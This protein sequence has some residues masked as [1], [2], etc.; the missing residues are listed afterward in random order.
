MVAHPEFPAELI[1]A[2]YGVS[3]GLH[4]EPGFTAPGSGDFRLTGGAAAKG[5]GIAKTLDLEDGEEWALPAGMD[6]G[7]W[8]GDSLIAPPAIAYGERGGTV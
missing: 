4:G 2:G 6:L 7:A 5:A 3:L 1:A 8:Q